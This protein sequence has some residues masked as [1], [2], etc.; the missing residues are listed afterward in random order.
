MSAPSQEPGHYQKVEAW[1]DQKAADYNA[2]RYGKGSV[3]QLSYLIRR[4]ITCSMMEQVRGRILDVGCGPGPFVERMM[5]EDRTLYTVDISANMVAEARKRQSDAGQTLHGFASNLIQ[6]G[7]ADE[8]FDGV[9]CIGVIGYIEE[10]MAAFREIYRV[11]KPGATAVIQTSNA[12]SIKEILYERWIPALKRLL[13]KRADGGGYGM[14]FQLR[15]YGKG[16][17]DRMVTDAGFE[18]QDWRYFNF[19]FPFTERVSKGLAV[20]SSEWL[21]R[22]GRWRLSFWLGGGYLVK[23]RKPIRK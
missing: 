4:D 18:L 11:M 17:F 22:F 5:R 1:H 13:G 21:Q 9:I 14:T 8:V 3:T 2:V 23:I 20:K 6:L 19:H 15:S 7:I 12:S 16:T 10:P